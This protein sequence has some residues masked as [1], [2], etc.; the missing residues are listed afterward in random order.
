MQFYKQLIWI[1]SSKEKVGDIS[2]KF[3]YPDI[4]S[5]LNFLHLA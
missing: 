2:K 5:A 1:W 4:D 3:I